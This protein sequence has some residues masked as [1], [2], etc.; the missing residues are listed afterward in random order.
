MSTE[1]LFL[2]A[3]YTSGDEKNPTR[4]RRPFTWRFNAPP[5]AGTEFLLCGDVSG[6]SSLRL[7]AREIVHLPNGEAMALVEIPWNEWAKFLTTKDELWCP[8]ERQTSQAA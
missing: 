4:W 7:P 2:E 6:P 1:A 5:V 3:F 8:V